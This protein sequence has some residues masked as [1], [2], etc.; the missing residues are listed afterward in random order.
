MRILLLVKTWTKEPQ[1]QWPNKAPPWKEKFNSLSS[2]LTKPISPSKS[3]GM[4]ETRLKTSI[5][6]IARQCP[7]QSAQESKPSTLLLSPCGLHI[8]SPT[9]KIRPSW[10]PREN[11]SREKI[12]SLD[13][14]A[15][16]HFT[17]SSEI[18]NWLLMPIQH[19]QHYKRHKEQRTWRTSQWRTKTGSRTHHTLSWMEL[20]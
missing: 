8:H 6:F 11:G 16:E 12:S 10:W 3:Q 13:T 4:Q 7:T 20:S 14:K 9:N 15:E 19:P 17:A 1:H 2:K 5:L 18:H